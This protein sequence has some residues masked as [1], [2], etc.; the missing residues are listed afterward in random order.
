MLPRYYRNDGE[1]RRFVRDLFDHG[2]AGYDRAEA[3]MALGS[4]SWYRRKALERAGLTPGMRVVDVAVG[5]GLVARQAVRLTGDS[6]LVLGLDPSS[7]ML[8]QVRSSLGIRIVQGRAE[9]MPL[10]VASADFVSMG[11][12]LRHLSDLLV[13]FAEFHRILRPGGKLCILE[14]VRP[15]GALAKAAL[16]L[17]IR[18]IIPAI[19]MV[20]F[21]RRDTAEL[22]KYYWETIQVCVPPEKV[23]EALR[24]C[25]FTDVRC[26][27]ELGIFVEYTATRPA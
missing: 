17:Y 20:T 16:G 7:G 19:A 11:Y 27:R 22:W 1:K 21:C 8:S 5:T 6:E 2:A 25:G 3:M 24:S 13:V 14:I 18:R 26:H 4:G 15:Q 23:L 10:E 9:E 12:A